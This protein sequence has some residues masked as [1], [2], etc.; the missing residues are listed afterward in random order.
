MHP[1]SFPEISPGMSFETLLI[2]G[3][4]ILVQ[5]F[6]Y[7]LTYMSTYRFIPHSEWD[8]Y[9]GSFINWFIFF[10]NFSVEIHPWICPEVFEI[11]L[12]VLIKT[13]KK[14]SKTSS[15]ECNEDFYWNCSKK[16]KIYV[17]TT[18]KFPYRIFPEN[19]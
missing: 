7:K 3:S 5:N 12:K 14:T 15:T 18:S 10:Q 13:S 11:F 8:Y 19:S 6:F 4:S 2:H 9:I 1:V 17:W 16:K